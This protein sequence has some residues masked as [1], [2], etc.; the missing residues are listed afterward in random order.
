MQGAH[1]A[2]TK[3]AAAI[4]VQRSRILVL[5]CGRGH[6]AAWFARAGHI[7]TAV[8]YSEDA[9][10]EAK[11]LYGDVADLTFA[12]EDAL[13]LPTK[14]TEAFD[15]VFD[16]TLYC[17]I[18]PARRGDLVKSWRKALTEN[19]HLLGIFFC[20]EKQKGPPYGGSEWE[21][22]S[23]LNKQFRTLFWQRLKDSPKE[24][25]SRLGSELFIYSQKLGSLR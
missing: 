5:G 8:D 24:N 11:H 18:D 21:L 1:P 15:I 6:D 3:M 9:I 16:H 14:Y 19:G 4:K 20:N 12:R 13:A 25:L 23:R 17:A 2:L 10:S 7:V 22:R